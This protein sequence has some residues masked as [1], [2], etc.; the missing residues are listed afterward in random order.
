MAAFAALLLLVLL[1]ATLAPLAVHQ[2]QEAQGEV[3]PTDAAGGLEPEVIG[4]GPRP[5]KDQKKAPCRAGLELELSGVCWLNLDQKPPKCPPETV[6]HEGK[7]LLPVATPR[8]VPTT[9]DGGGTPG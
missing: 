8:R 4:A 9:V 7:C 2:V 6:A 5:L 3:W 1:P